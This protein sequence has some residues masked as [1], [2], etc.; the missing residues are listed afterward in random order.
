MISLLGSQIHS[1]DKVL[2]VQHSQTPLV[3]SIASGGQNNDCILRVHCDDILQFTIE[4]E[5]LSSLHLLALPSSPSSAFKA[6]DNLTS[7]LLESDLELLQKVRYMILFRYEVRYIKF[8][9]L[10][11]CT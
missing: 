10:R 4:E 1:K 2:F 7:S 6:V 9:V 3:C 11:T 8:N 5:L